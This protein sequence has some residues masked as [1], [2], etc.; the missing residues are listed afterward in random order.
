L[1]AAIESVQQ[2]ISIQKLSIFG[3]AGEMRVTAIAPDR[4]KAVAFRSRLEQTEKFQSIDLPLGL[5]RAI[6]DRI[7]FTITTTIP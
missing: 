3:D 4:A 6:P 1:Q 5:I 7:E 2:D